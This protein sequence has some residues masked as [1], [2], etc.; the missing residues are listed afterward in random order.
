MKIADKVQNWFDENKE[1]VAFVG[2]FTVGCITLIG[3][4]YLLG[5]GKGFDKGFTEGGKAVERFVMTQDPEAYKRLCDAAAKIG[6]VL[7]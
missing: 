4:G 1:A 6:K 7:K 2:V 5:L 3:G